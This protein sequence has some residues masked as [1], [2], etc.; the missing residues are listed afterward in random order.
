MHTWGEVVVSPP[1]VILT[2]AINVMKAY[3]CCDNILNPKEN[4]IHY[5]HEY[6]F[7]QCYFCKTKKSQIIS[8]ILFEIF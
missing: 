1:S 4:N 7:D 2:F 6:S 5:K 8:K 3:L